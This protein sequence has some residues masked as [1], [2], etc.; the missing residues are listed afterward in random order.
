VTHVDRTAAATTVPGLVRKVVSFEVGVWRS[1]YRWTTRRPR[2]PAGAETFGYAGPVTP[3]IWAFIGLSAVE[4]P[5]A[6]LLL[7]WQTAR[8][9]VLVVGVWGLTW[10]F[11]F[12][13]SLKTYPHVVADFGLRIRYGATVDIAI[14][15]GAIASIGVR[16]RNLP[17]SRTVQLRSVD[18]GTV[19]HVGISSQTNVDVALRHP[20]TVLLPRGS[21]PITAVHFY[22]DDARALVAEAR[23]HLTP[24]R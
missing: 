22:A 21:E 14:P 7:P 12:L 16:H 20:V 15:W 8:V 17:S 1:L 2:G 10:M 11:G 3:L 24:I 23:R 9:V 5:V 6:H 19:V 13:A 4:I 18:A